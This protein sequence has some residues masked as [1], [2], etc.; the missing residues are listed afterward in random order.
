MERHVRVMDVVGAI[1]VC[2]TSMSCRERC[3]N[4]KHAGQWGHQRCAIEYFCLD[5]ALQSS[6][7]GSTDRRI[8]MHVTKRNLKQKTRFI[9]KVAATWTRVLCTVTTRRRSKYGVD[10]FE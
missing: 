10:K 6:A 8:V 5:T 4:G 2:S 1:V 3:R 9:R 7:C